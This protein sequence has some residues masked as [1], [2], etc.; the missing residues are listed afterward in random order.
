MKRCNLKTFVVLNKKV[1]SKIKGKLFQLSEEKNLVSKF[2]IAARNRPELELE[3]YIGNFEFSVV[4]KSL[5]TSDGMP[6]A[7]NDKSSLQIKSLISIPQSPIS[8]VQNNSI[9]LCNVSKKIK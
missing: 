6:L 2:L 3:H 5:F 7:C 9:R 4:P 8:Q 1:R